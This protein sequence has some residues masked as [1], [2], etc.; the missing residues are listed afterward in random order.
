MFRL[1][2]LKYSANQFSIIYVIYKHTHFHKIS[3]KQYIYP[4]RVELTIRIFPLHSFLFFTISILHP[5]QISSPMTSINSF[6]DLLLSRFPPI[7]YLLVFLEYRHSSTLNTS[8]SS[9]S[10]LSPA[11]SVIPKLPLT[12]LILV[13]S[14]QITHIHLHVSAILLFFNLPTFRFIHDA[15]IPS[16]QF[17]TTS[18]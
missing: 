15:H 6:F 8:I 12:I 18:L 16:Q 3:K 5:I 14:E 2:K 11:T 10:I 4:T 1:I 17:Y 9:Q 7:F 13:L